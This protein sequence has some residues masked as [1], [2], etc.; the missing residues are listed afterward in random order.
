MVEL[1]FIEAEYLR[2][3]KAVNAIPPNPG[4][5][6]RSFGLHTIDEA[7]KLLEPDYL[8]ANNQENGP[9]IAQG[10]PP[11][12]PSTSAIVTTILSRLLTTY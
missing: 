4:Q 1:L 10:R 3:Q 7:Q 6:Q 5:R 8:R 2:E 11:I 9:S 12:V